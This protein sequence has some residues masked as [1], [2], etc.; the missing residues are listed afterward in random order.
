MNRL[1]VRPIILALSVLFAGSC[2]R[3]VY[4]ISWEGI[5]VEENTARP[6]PN[7]QVFASCVY[8]EN[9]DETSKVEDH[10]VTDENGRFKLSFPKGFGL[11]VKTNATGYLSGVDYKIIKKPDIADTIFISSCPF[12]TS[13]VVRMRNNGK[14]RDEGEDSFNL[15]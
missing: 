14:P 2:A 7:A 6:V 5:V 3:E 15:D 12:N 1:Y 8:Q 10:A 13:L 9:I 4:N 11:T